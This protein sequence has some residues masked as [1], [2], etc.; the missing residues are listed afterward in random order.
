MS[1]F[2]ISDHPH[3]R[4]NALT[5]EWILVSPHRAKR[6][7]NGQVEK[8]A[9]EV[10]PTYDPNCYLCPGNTRVSGDVNPKYE[11]NFV[12]TNDFAAL[13]PDTPLNGPETDD[14]FKLEPARGTA[15]VICFSADH[16]KNLPGMEVDEIRSVVDL[17]ASQLVEL[18]ANFK[19]VQLFENKG[20]IMG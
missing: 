10:K 7:W 12:F 18:G 14:L 2:H 9:N 13:M 15:R 5:G 8:A 1:A 17:W 11:R 20:A 6:P 3:R 16:S 19:W 4:F